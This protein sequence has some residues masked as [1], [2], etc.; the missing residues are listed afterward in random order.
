MSQIRFWNLLAKKMA[1]EALPE[2][3]QELE[4]LI[5]EN[6]DW[7]Y[8]AEHLQNLWKQ[9]KEG[10]PYES[11]LAFDLHVNKLKEAGIYLPEQDRPVAVEEFAEPIH[12]TKGRK[13]LWAAGFSV[14]LLALAGGWIWLGNQ[15]KPSPARPSRNSEVSAP[16]R[17]KTNLVLPDNTMVW[18][19]ADSKLTYNEGF[20][21][22][23]R[24]VTLTGEAFF[25]VKKSTIPFVIHANDIRI[26]VL[27]TAFN[28]KAYPN[29]KTTETSLIRGRIE[30]SFDKRPGEKFFLKPNEKLIVANEAGKEKKTGKTEPIVVLK[31]LT[32]TLDSIIV[33]TSWLNNK[34][35]FQDESFS[36]IAEKMQRWYGVIIEFKD[37]RIARERMS[38][39]FTTETIQEALERLQMTTR[40]HFTLKSNTIIITQ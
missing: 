11:E 31:E 22:S 37:E 38:G 3:L 21:I 28:V 8:P 5:S 39:T 24:N 40:F 13:K 29:E 14:I 25:D 16:P 35:V 26:K 2:E 6:P 30:V 20:G 4:K 1:G 15:K 7:V 12:N 32:R 9:K 19:N 18:L 23:N 36:E 33:E 17:S 34:L 10:D 27:G